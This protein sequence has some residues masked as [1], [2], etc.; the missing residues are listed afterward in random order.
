M[1]YIVPNAIDIGAKYA[2]LD[3]AEPDALDF[4]ILGERS[5]GVLVGG[6]VTHVPASTSVYV[7]AGF[8][9]LRGVVYPLNRNGAK[10]V[11]KAMIGLPS[12][13]SNN[14]RFDLV[15]ARLSTV[16]QKPSMEIVVLIGPESENNPTFPA[17]PSRV[18]PLPTEDRYFDPT[19]DVLLASVYRVGGSFL[20]Q[21][22]IVDKRVNVLSTTMVRGTAV[23]DNTFGSDGD[24]YYRLQTPSNASGLYIKK[25]AVWIELILESDFKAANPIGTIIMWPVS[26]NPSTLYWREC[27]GTTLLK[28]EFPE[29]YAL[30]GTTYGPE[31]V[32]EFTIPNLQDRFIRGSNTAGLGGGSDSV[33][34]SISNIPAHNHSIDGHTH[35]IG[36]HTHNINTQNQN[37]ITSEAGNHSHFGD[38]A[39]NELVVRLATNPSGNYV[40]PYSSKVVGYADGMHYNYSG[41]G[42]QAP[43]GNVTSQGGIT[44]A[45]RPSTNVTG[46]HTHTVLLNFTGV[47]EPSASGETG[48]SIQQNTGTVGSGSAF[49]NIPAYTT[50]RWFIKVR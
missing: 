9:A 20:T 17:S 13:L 10:I 35:N 48:P 18:E 27:N 25:N 34:L 14:K 44:V 31:T 29:L 2:S 33:S 46:S 3:Q 37:V 32:T 42:N 43:G 50:M 26:T 8:V 36:S 12:I 45:A 41:G 1:P 4:Q 39:G 40:A 19:R 47:V 11:G 23:P 22:N 49:S 6:G 28:S 7:D 15:V 30:L 21:A 38:T 5:S 16:D 24:F